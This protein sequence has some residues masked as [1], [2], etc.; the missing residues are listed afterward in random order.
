M[1]FVE[2]CKE[3]I[4]NG[5]EYINELGSRMYLVLG[6][7]CFDYEI[8]PG[9]RV[10]ETTI[11]GMH[12]GQRFKGDFCEVVDWSKVKVN[13]L[14]IYT[15]ENGI[16]EKGHFKEY[17]SGIDDRVNWYANGQTSFTTDGYVRCANVEYCKLA[18][19]GEQ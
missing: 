5:K 17:T 12:I 2:A 14:I 8:K 1:N 4:I 19:E 16:K 3:T 7:I 15:G 18:E 6:I 13:E 10:Q 9:I 11:S